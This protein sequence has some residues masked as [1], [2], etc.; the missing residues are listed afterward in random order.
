[1]TLT[2]PAG[3]RGQQTIDAPVYNLVP[4]EGEPARFGFM[5]SI[6]PV[7]LDTVVKDFMS[8][9]EVPGAMVTMFDNV[10]FMSP[11]DTKT[12]DTLGLAARAAPPNYGNASI[13]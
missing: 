9:K 10:N 13:I 6:V 5:A 12:A 8:K 4:A 3:L 7:T 2:E 1:M 11:F